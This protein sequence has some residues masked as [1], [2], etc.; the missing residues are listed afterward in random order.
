MLGARD[1]EGGD[2]G[3]DKGTNQPALRS[4]GINI[5]WGGAGVCA[6]QP[7]GQMGARIDRCMKVC[8]DR[9]IE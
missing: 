5:V 1:E 7:V 9:Q 8:D 4:S 3:R 6:G 2:V